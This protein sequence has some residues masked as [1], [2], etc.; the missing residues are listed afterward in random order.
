M[1]PQTAAQRTS[2]EQW[3][4]LRQVAGLCL[5]CLLWCLAYASVLACL[6][7]VTFLVAAATTHPAA[8]NY[9]TINTINS[10]VPHN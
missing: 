5:F 4:E 10:T 2:A 3:Q 1:L 8:L 7:A 6:M 9:D